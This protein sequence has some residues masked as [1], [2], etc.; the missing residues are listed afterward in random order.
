MKSLCQLTCNEFLK[1]KSKQKK[2]ILEILL[3]DKNKD[4]S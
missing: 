1:F 4:M 2:I 3:K